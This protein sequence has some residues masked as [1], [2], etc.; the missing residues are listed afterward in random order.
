MYVVLYLQSTIRL[1]FV[2][3]IYDDLVFF[4]KLMHKVDDFLVRQRVTCAP[5]QN[6]SKTDGMYNFDV[7]KHCDMVI[8]MRY[9][10][11]VVPIALGVPTI[12]LS[13]MDKCQE[14]YRVLGLLDRCLDIRS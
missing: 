8:A 12:M 1:V 9:H 14:L 11:N 6:G 13:A 10:A 3:H 5:Y 2:P 4:S 7:Y